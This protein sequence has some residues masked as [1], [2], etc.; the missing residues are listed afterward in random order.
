MASYMRQE[1]V[2]AELW[3]VGPTKAED[4]DMMHR[5]SQVA[6]S[7]LLVVCSALSSFK[8][9][10]DEAMYEE[11]DYLVTPKKED[12]LSSPGSLSGDSVT[13]L[14]YYTGDGENSDYKSASEPTAQ[15]T[16]NIPTEDYD[17][18]DVPV[19]EAPP[20]SQLSEGKVPSEEENGM[21]ASQ[22]GEWNE[23]ISYQLVSLTWKG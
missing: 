10:L 19:P 2:E 23:L 9:A 17:D 5:V 6:I 3:I 15:R 21:R 14:P 8:D 11:I 13:K 20:A 16:N 12:L 4:A 1:R 18:E 22:T 7:D